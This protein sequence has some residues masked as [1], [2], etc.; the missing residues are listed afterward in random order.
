MK[1]AL[2][3]LGLILSF[4]QL[5][6]Q[7]QTVSSAPELISKIISVVGLKPNFEV[8]ASNVPNAA[9]VVSNGKRYILY[10]Q[11]FITG[12]VKIS[13][14]EWSAVS[15]LAHEIGHH[16]NGHTLDNHGSVPSEE[17]DAD[18][19]SGFVLRKMGATLDEAQLATKMAADAR[20][21]T[22]HPGA[23]DRLAAIEKGWNNANNQL[24]GKVDLAINQPKVQTGPAVTLES[25]QS[26]QQ[27]VLAD[28]YIAAN[29]Y[30]NADTKG[31][32]FVTTK[33][34]LVKIQ[35][36][37]LFLI[38]KVSPLQSTDY[39]LLIHDEDEKTQLFVD[40]EGTIVTPKGKKVGRMEMH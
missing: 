20:A 40:A 5:F 13:G 31:K 11:N 25:L 9:A 26:Q 23:Y 38:G 36:N 27:T 39:P 37:Q 28:K 32:Y 22:T 29:V 1:K 12:L 14:N 18:E 21:T 34:N 10:N 8:R 24:L 17:L 4:A 19:F 15:V 3:S 30:F 33:L 35:D 7:T 16:L 6:A 2:F